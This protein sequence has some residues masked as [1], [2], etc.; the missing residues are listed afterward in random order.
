MNLSKQKRIA[1]INDVTG[2]GRCSVAVALP[3]IS[4]M[5]IQCCPLPTAILSSQTSFPNFFFDD[6]TPHMRSYMNNWKELNLKFDGICTGFLS[7]KEQIDIVV[8]FFQKFKSQ[9]TTVI[10]D[11]VMGDY[12]QLYSTYT[13]EMCHEMKRL[14]K[15]ADV[16]TPNLTEACRLLDIPYP[17]K[18]LSH[19][20]LE[21]IA[22]ELCEKGPDKIVITGLQ[23]NGNIQNFVY[24][25]GK[26]YTII[27]VKKIGEDRSGTGDVF[28]SIVAANIVKGVEL[29]TAVKK[30]TDFI[31][32]A[33][34]YTA[35][36]GTPVYDGIC[37][38]E[39]LT[40]LR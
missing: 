5:K 24:E 6:Y 40:E 4:A 37:F 25:T 15:Y 14:M 12:G 19:D 10:V 22:K 36:I 3:I 29:I 28:T 34:D 20:E 38:E 27:N 13:Q 23:N 11:P 31:S 16:M 7:S 33:I 9:N 8:E 35:K 17:D 26:P 39:Y 1:V 32:K 2:F 18:S 21:D 30:A